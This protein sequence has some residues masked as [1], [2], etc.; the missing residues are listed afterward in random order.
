MRLKVYILS[1]ADSLTKLNE[2]YNLGGR[3]KDAHI[4]ASL[5]GIREL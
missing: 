2:M 3:L 5:E 1:E 4:A